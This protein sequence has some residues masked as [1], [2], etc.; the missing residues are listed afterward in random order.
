MLQVILFILKLIGWILLVILGLL[1]LVLAAV[2]FTPLR[3]E[4]EA[5]CPG[6]L[7]G[8]EA[9]VS[10]RF[11]FRLVSGSFRYQNKKFSWTARAAWIRL[12][13]QAD[14]K[15]AGEETE[16]ALSDL[17]KAGEEELERIAEEP[18]GAAGE[19][20][21]AAAEEPE[22]AAGE[23]SE[24]AAENPEGAEVRNPEPAAEEKKK[25]IESESEA[26]DS[27]KGSQGAEK[28]ADAG[29]GRTGGAEKAGKPEEEYRTQNAEPDKKPLSDK[30]A[31][32]LK[33]IKYTF[34]RM[35]D[36]IKI[37]LEK[38]EILEEF[39]ASDVH[40]SAFGKCLSEL[41]KMLL[42]LRPR[43]IEGK[44]RFGFEDPS[45]TG[46]VLAGLSLLFP[47]W[48]E[49]IR[50]FPD[51]EEKVLEG[52]LSVSGSLRLLPAAAMGW[53]LL[54]NRNVRRTARDAIRLTARL[55]K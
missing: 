8:L 45:L 30:I 47:Y 52:R 12:G 20:P 24:A 23:N 33:K 7:S 37:L 1:I 25:A 50:C 29:K 19:A 28:N 32:F 6:T 38:K 35:C 48:G 3:Y 15:E 42:R 14:A 5:D 34:D 39:L 53:N 21:G 17:A 36:K 4:A 31:A 13:D 40:Q 2:L 27:E 41:K 26:E 54:W 10:F 44:F 22:E 16:E 43:H 55:R 18:E 49:H 9:G 51:F 46:K 11:F